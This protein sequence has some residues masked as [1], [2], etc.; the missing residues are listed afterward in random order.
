MVTACERHGRVLQVG[1]M[2]R[3]N[4]AFRKAAELVRNGYI[5]KVKEVLVGLGNFLNQSFG[6]R[7]R[8]LR[9]LIMIVGSAPRPMSR[10]L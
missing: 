6:Q 9:A 5:G 7:S 4:S 8:F 2:Q 1:S 10:I 3:S